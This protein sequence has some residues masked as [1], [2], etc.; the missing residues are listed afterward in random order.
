MRAAGPFD[1]FQGEGIRRRLLARWVAPAEIARFREARVLAAV[2]LA[3]AA[4]VTGLPARAQ[5]QS[6]AAVPPATGGSAVAAQTQTQTQTVLGR[7]ELPIHDVAR[8]GTQAEMERWLRATPRDRD[9]RAPGGATP[10][11]YAAINPDPGPLK[12]L[13]A[14]GANPNARDAEGRTPMHM[15]AFATRTAHAKR[16]LRAGGD[17][18]LKT[19][20]GRD[21]LSMARRVRADEL[22]GEVSLWILKGCTPE[23]PC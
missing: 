22:A 19:D 10:L 18:L 9:A 20:A 3:I 13:L 6:S 12:A 23:K 5:T 1:E 4:A 7:H 16:L 11:H 17:P 21:V 15:A 8:T 14:A 2:T